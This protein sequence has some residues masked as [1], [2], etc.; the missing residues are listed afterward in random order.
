MSHLK[1]PNVC[2][3][4]SFAPR[5]A[6][7]EKHAACVAFAFCPVR[8]CLLFALPFRPRWPVTQHRRSGDDVVYAPAIR[9][10]E[11]AQ[12]PRLHCGRSVILAHRA[13]APLE[14]D[15]VHCVHARRDRGSSQACTQTKNIPK[16]D[17]PCFVFFLP[18]LL[19]L[20]GLWVTKRE[21]IDSA[22]R[23]CEVIYDAACQWDFRA[24]CL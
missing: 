4:R 22:S 23:L 10:D 17:S 7:C 12:Q 21:G 3:R 14:M 19:L 5:E 16:R 13:S 18:V 9:D 24:G 11:T 6:E 1:T 20:S 8:L 2:M 15:R